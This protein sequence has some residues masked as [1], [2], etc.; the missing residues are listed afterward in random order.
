MSVM[1]TGVARLFF[2][3][4]EKD[5]NSP[6]IPIGLNYEYGSTFR[7]SV[8]M[9]IAK[10]L[11]TDDVTRK[12]RDSPQDAVRELTQRV[13]NALEECVFQSEN[14]LDRELTLYLER[15]Y[16]EDKTSDSWLERLERLKQFE[17]GLNALR[18]CCKTEINRLRQM[19]SRHKELAHSLEKMRYSPSDDISRSAKRLFMGLIGLPF[20]AMGC[21]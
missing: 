19:L 15:I 21:L 18:D 10:P 17:A 16:N 1:K 3:A 4:R 6:I 12:Y 11:E 20:S 9:W 13:G 7:T 5:I 2:L 8:V 14:F